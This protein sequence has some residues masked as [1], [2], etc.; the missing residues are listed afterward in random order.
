MLFAD[1]IGQDILKIK[2][3]NML[4]QNRLSHALL[5][6]GNE[7]SGALPLA[8]AFAS[9]VLLPKETKAE[10]AG[11]FG[12][13]PSAPFTAP[14]N[15]QEAD[16]WMKQQPGFKKLEELIH[17]DFHFSYPVFKKEHIEKP[18]S[19]DFAT[20]WRQFVKEQPYG[21]L[22]NWLQFIKAENKQGNIS[23]EECN[24]I[25]RK[26]SLKSFESG[27]KV[28]LMWM[29]E[30]LGKEGN[31][32]LKLIEEPPPFT[33]FLLVA[34]NENKILP[35]ILS[36]TQLI[37]VPPLSASE[38]AQG[39]IDKG[40][41]AN[42]QHAELTASLANGNFLEAINQTG[43]QDIDREANLRTWLNSIVQNKTEE[44]YKWIEQTAKLGREDQKQLLQFFIHII[45]L[46]IRTE[47][48]APD[49]ATA[50]RP[51]MEMAIRLNKLCGMAEKEAILN[52][53]YEAIYYIERNA[54]S[55]ML[56]HALTIKLYHIIRNK[57]LILA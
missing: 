28:L 42:P 16:A 11:L 29:P 49:P 1:V 53:L 21:N 50:E 20:E 15:P 41:A 44:Q 33:L 45:E 36:R 7:G 39:L 5:F 46:A 35:T 51:D 10:P 48:I 57:S 26:M 2:L 37:R 55:K 17:P 30:A 23:V 12:D 8:I 13:A 47:W 18:K 22:Y 14:K 31:K 54:N 4:E 43:R 25:V 27:M 40:I 3:L 32:L 24:D 56:F 52:Q 38:I 9:Y 34:E 6:L 19:A